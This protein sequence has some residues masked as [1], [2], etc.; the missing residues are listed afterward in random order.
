MKRSDLAVHDT[1]HGEWL[2]ATRRRGRGRRAARWA[3]RSRET[4]GNIQ[5]KLTPP[6]IGPGGVSDEVFVDFF[7]PSGFFTVEAHPECAHYLDD[8]PVDIAGRPKHLAYPSVPARV[9][10]E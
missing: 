3:A 10:R 8:M 9:R 6:S 7:D 1:N 2:S 5:L 4:P